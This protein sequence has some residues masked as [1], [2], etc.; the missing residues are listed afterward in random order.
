MRPRRSLFVSAILWFAAIPPIALCASVLAPATAYPLDIAAN[1]AAQWA[2][3]A[4]AWAFVAL[5]FRRGLLTLICLFAAAFPVWTLAQDRA[6]IL[7]LPEVDAAVQ[8][9]DRES[10]AIIRVL[11][12]NTSANQSDDR[13]LDDLN[14]Y[15]P[16]IIAVTEPSGFLW[17]DRTHLI[18]RNPA[19]HD[20]Q[21]EPV[22]DAIGRVA[23]WADA[24]RTMLMGSGLLA[25]RWPMTAWDIAEF[26]DAARRVIAGRVESPHGPFIVLAAHP[27]SPRDETRWRFGN[28][29]VEVVA[30]AARKAESLG[31]PVI[32]LA[33]LN[34]T[35][36]GARSRRL[37]E[38]GLRR[39]KPLL[40]PLGT[41][42]T[43][44]VPG[45]RGAVGR[46]PL[47]IAIDD[48]LVSR[49]WS[50]RAWS[51]GESRGSDHWPIL[52]DLH[53]APHP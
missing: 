13:V 17:R 4:V 45:V 42:P 16:D 35:P 38:S 8:P 15:Q 39:T 29:D 28:D 34:S 30:Q 26:G 5:L 6:A 24:E 7:P 27:R 31:L 52:A 9:A 36:S 21:S 18:P 53:L 40:K 41:W 50:V 11:H 47:A 33:D 49:H 44:A 37:A 51:R 10:R 3:L 12:F 14:L 43:Q 20:P 23:F 1:L 46:W 22:N 2:L 48:A 25:S 19:D 32:V